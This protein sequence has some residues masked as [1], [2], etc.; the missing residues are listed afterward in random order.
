MFRKFYKWCM[1]KIGIKKYGIPSTCRIW[2][3]RRVSNIICEGY[4]SISKDAD[5]HNVFLGYASGISR[6]SEFSNTKVGKYTV[7]GPRV[8]IIRGEHPTHGFVSVHPAFYSLRKQ[9]GF[10]YT[11]R[12]KYTE[13][14]WAD[15]ENDI[16]VIVGND[17]WIGS[18]VLIMEGVKIGDGA[19]IAAGAVITR[20][21]LPYAIVGGVPAKIIRYRFS[22]NDI[23]KLLKLKWWDKGEDWIKTYAKY[24]DDVSLLF[25]ELRRQQDYTME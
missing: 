21:V 7:M 15:E 2:P 5:A 23:V 14:R 24:F 12:Q 8:R 11:D 6:G 19:I 3:S 17:V 20:D 16:S 1:Y 25:E 18:D 9:Y 22:Q 10:T 4:N 13:F